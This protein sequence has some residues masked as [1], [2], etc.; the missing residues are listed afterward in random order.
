MNQPN[1]RKAIKLVVIALALVSLAQTITAKPPVPGDLGNGNTGIGNGVLNS[2]VSGTDNSAFGFESLFGN[3]TGSFNSGM[4]YQ[5]LFTNTTGNINTASGFQALVSN[6]TG[7]A[8]TATGAEALFFSTIGNENTASGYLAL[9]ANNTGNDNTAA[10]ANS[11][12]H[13]TTGSFNTTSGSFALQASTTGGFNTAM[14]SFSLNANTTGDNNIALGY[15]AGINL[16]TG[17]NNI[18]IGN[19]G[20]TGESST[21][22]IGTAGS[23]TSTFVAGVFGAVVTGVPVVVDTNGQLGTIVSSQ[24]F[25][26]D[27]K[28]MDKASEAI[29]SLK[30]V[31][32][33]YKKELDPKGDPQFGLVAEEVAKVNPNLVVR[34]AQGKIYTVRYDAVNAMLLNEFLKQHHQAEEQK[35]TITQLNATVA[36]QE[37]EIAALTAGLREQASQIQKVSAQIAAGGS[38]VQVVDSR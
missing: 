16:T 23:Q 29:F 34:D 19:Q 9:F 21:I 13:N 36:Q 2:N 12:S 14:G 7:S 10:G 31:T 4:G 28:P 22:R 3:T 24:H 26:T 18:D 30:P 32:F 20:V 15:S 27:I 35:A 11:L 25:K 5:T 38:T 17:A 1:T 33:Q 8:N 6:T 37:K